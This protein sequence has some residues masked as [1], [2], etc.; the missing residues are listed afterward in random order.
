MAR[1]EQMLDAAAEE[2]RAARALDPP[3]PEARAALTRLRR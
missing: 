3:D 2:Y 1:G